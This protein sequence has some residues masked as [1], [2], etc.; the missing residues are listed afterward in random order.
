MTNQERQ[1]RVERYRK[2]SLEIDDQFSSGDDNVKLREQLQRLE[3]EA[4]Q[5]GDRDYELFFQ[6]ELIAYS[7]NPDNDKCIDLRN[8]ALR[9]ADQQS[10]GEDFFIL[11]NI[12][13][14]YAKKG[15]FDEAIKWFDKALEVKPDDYNALRDKGAVYSNKSDFDETIRWCDKAL[16]FKP[17]DYISLRGKGVVYLNKSDFNEAITWFDKALEIKPDDYASLRGKGVSYSK[18]HD[19]DESLKW[20][21]NALK[22]KPGDIDSIQW[23]LASLLSLQ[24]TDEAET[25]FEEKEQIFTDKKKEFEKTYFKTKIES[26]KKHLKSVPLYEN[27]GN[28]FD[29]F[30]EKKEEEEELINSYLVRETKLPKDKYSLFLFLRRW[31]S[32]TPAIP[33]TRDMSVGGGYFLWH[34]NEGTVIDPGYKFLENFYEAGGTIS[35]I[36][37]VV[38]THAHDDHNH[39][40]EQLCTLFYKYNELC[41]K[42]KR[43]DSKLKI[44]FFLNAGAFKKFSGM[45]DLNDYGYTDHLFVMSEGST[46]NLSGDA[47]KKAGKIHVLPAY[48]HE[49]LSRDQAVGL[50]FDLTSP[51]EKNRHRILLTSDTGLFPQDLSGTDPKKPKNCDGSPIYEK[52][53]SFLDNNEVDLMVVHIGSIKKTERDGIGRSFDSLSNRHAICYPNHLGYIGTR[54]VIQNIK[55]KVAVLSE[56]GEEMKNFR[57]P[58]CRDI[59]DSVNAYLESKGQQGKITVLPSDIP[60]IYRFFDNDKSEGEIWDCVQDEWIPSVDANYENEDEEGSE[61][62]FYMEDVDRYAKDRKYYSDKF[63]VNMKYFKSL[64]FE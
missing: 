5:A 64:Y 13:V 61:S 54:E 30:I 40:F 57:M 29:R 48:H 49:L 22:I 44:R 3:E 23:K 12:G 55:P 19:F 17:D 20:L 47:K 31:N 42:E 16:K 24:K 8:E 41:E 14:S 37:N 15:D 27:F 26:A 43:E 45:I 56:W 59:Y 34:A 2:A 52:Y 39:Q 11:R 63:R 36:H 32:Y 58:L 35:D 25:F 51:D 18:K 46:F 10:L 60:L 21:D 38:V 4:K 28:N 53:K 1:L 9:Y 62:I 33:R 6:S 7:D 50:Y